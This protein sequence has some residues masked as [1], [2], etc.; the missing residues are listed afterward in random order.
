MIGPWCSIALVCLLLAMMFA[1]L[2]LIERLLHPHPELLRKLLHVGMGLV[3][4]SFPWV[5]HQRWPVV[6]LAGISAALLTAIKLIP[7]LH[8][9][10]GTILTGV[11]RP[12]LGEVCFPISVATLFLICRGDKILFVVPMLI[13]T[14]ADAVAALVGITYGKVRYVTSD[15]FKSAEGS[16]AFLFIAFLAIH[17]P[18]LLFTPIGRLEVLLM[19][20]IIGLLS[21]MLE[22][23]AARGLD[24]LLIPLGAFAFLR[25]YEHATPHAL[26]IRL[27]ATFILLIFV[28]SWRGRSTLDDSA[29]IA[30]ALFGYGAAM[31]GGAAWLVGP[32]SLFVVHVMM[33]PRFDARRLHTVYSVASVT[34]AGLFWLILHAAYPETTRVFFPYAAGFGAHLA[35]IGVSR[36]S[37]DASPRPRWLRLAISVMIGCALTG[38]QMLPILLGSASAFVSVRLAFLTLVAIVSIAVGA[39]GFYRL[40]P[41]L[42]GDKG[43]DPAIHF[44]G[45]A[46]ALVGS[47]IA[48]ALQYLQPPF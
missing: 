7:K 14:L 46:A 27:A 31:L 45:F 12:S 24:N 32:L 17:V 30:C 2:K 48:F 36:I 25:L 9:G 34:L 41:Y 16:M 5:F 47:M 1:A 26:L 8:D 37:I 33:W 19:A 42:Y 4:I 3:V 13:M 35:I 18:L 11:H 44:A 6:L 20:A 23:I 22:A 10:I 28:L 15:G 40:L 39:G 43:S 38:L 21:T 29:L